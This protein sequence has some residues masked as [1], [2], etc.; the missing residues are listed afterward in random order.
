MV[1]E[2][3]MQ[4]SIGSGRACL[5]RSELCFRIFSSQ[6]IRIFCCR[7]TEVVRSGD[8]GVSDWN[9]KRG[10][11]VIAALECRIFCSDC[12]LTHCELQMYKKIR[13]E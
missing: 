4:C 8:G 13:Q 11:S 1:A 10:D 6:F 7:M 9:R 3:Q 12:R 2:R 5:N